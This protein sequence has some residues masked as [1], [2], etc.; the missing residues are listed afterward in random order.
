MC[1]APETHPTSVAQAQTTEEPEAPPESP[2]PPS[3]DPSVA[4]PSGV[5]A[6][7]RTHL[8]RG[9][10]RAARELL[11]AAL[12]GTEAT[13]SDALHWLAAEA[14]HAGGD[15]AAG[16]AHYAQIVTDSPLSAWGRLRRAGRATPD[17]ALVLLAGLDA[18]P[19]GGRERAR[20]LRARSLASLGR[21]D[22]AAPA[23]RALVAE[24]PDR[25]GAALAAMPL[26]EHLAASE[27]EE[28]R[29]EALRLYRRVATRGPRTRVGR[30]AGE[31][32][33]A[34][35]ATLPASRQ[36][37]LR[38]LPTSDRLAEARALASSQRHLEA[39]RAYRRVRRALVGRGP[40]WCRAAMGEAQALLRRRERD[41]AAPLLVQVAE[42]CPAER[43]AARFR[44]GRA[45]HRMGEYEDAR[46]QLEA[47]QRDDPTHRLA[48]DAL[49][50]IA[51][52][53]ESQG[54]ADEQE[55]ALEALPARYPEGDMRAEAL[56]QLGQRK[57]NAG[58]HAAA[59]PFFTRGAEIGETERLE[60]IDGRARYWLGRTF[61]DL[62]RRD[63][64]IDTYR[65]LCRA[66]PLAYYAQLAL[67]RLA[68]LDPST[69]EVIEAEWRRPAEA[70]RFPARPVND[71]PSF[72]AAIALLRVGAFEEAEAEL[73]SVGALGAGADEGV[74]WMVAGLYEAAG[75]H[76]RAARLVRRR[77]DTFRGFHPGGSGHG[78]W[79]LAYPR[80]FAPLVEESAREVSVEPALLRALAR[81]ESSFDPRARSWAQAYGLVQVILP[82]ARRFGAE[83]ET[84][85]DARTMLRPEVNLA[86]GARYLKFL[87]ERFDD[88]LVPAAYNAGHSAVSRWRRRARR[89]DVATFIES[90]PYDET[91]RYTRRV[92]QTWGVYAF[93]DEGR[94]VPFE[95]P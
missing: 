3:F 95:T 57:R 7:A 73:R 30:E 4:R 1:G 77:L 5:V 34:V 51:R 19:W 86:V 67:G 43:T 74:L 45:L 91:R 68:D 55:A 93:L 65:G 17:E 35:L 87:G 28:D 53:Y 41:D 94:L 58:E 70:L 10:H 61:E 25:R 63:E 60:G 36:A 81:E 79:R 11:S 14:A 83:L 39:A 9:E 2:S 38:A 52:T 88:A 23:L 90:I 13:D 84:P 89:Q 75:A 48:D 50:R 32:A 27:S 18:R 29:V 16:D 47:L 62:G 72:H 24:A 69:R 31:R 78:Y 21:W 64:A 59:L 20:T 44:A 40:E 56:F 49:F 22:E 76:P 82:T 92:L 8:R 42:R 33:E 15:A 71:E 46:E 66:H 6:E 26:A 12:A 85:I 80:A 54:R 37:E